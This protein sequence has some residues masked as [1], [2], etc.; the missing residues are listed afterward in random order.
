MLDVIPILD[1]GNFRKEDLSAGTPD[2]K[3]CHKS[4]AAKETSLPHNH[5]DIEN[6]RPRK[7]RENHDGLI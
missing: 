6:N 5:A 7:Y 1:H 2:T 4:G 3:D